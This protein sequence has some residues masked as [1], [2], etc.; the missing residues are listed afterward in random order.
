MLCYSAASSQRSCCAPASQ[1]RWLFCLLQKVVFLKFIYRSY[2]YISMLLVVLEVPFLVQNSLTVLLESNICRLSS[3][4][5]KKAALNNTE[6]AAPCLPVIVLPA[7]LELHVS[8]LLKHTNCTQLFSVTVLYTEQHW[9]AVKLAWEKSIHYIW[10]LGSFMPQ[11]V[12]I[13]NLST[14]INI[15]QGRS[16]KLRF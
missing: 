15:T 14:S 7:Q 3:H 16:M 1:C 12:L 6:Y 11:T 2:C 8:H 5:T 10:Q 4:I 13:L 9:D